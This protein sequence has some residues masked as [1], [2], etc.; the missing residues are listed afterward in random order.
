MFV[1]GQ[2]LVEVTVAEEQ[3]APQPAMRLV[4]G[5]SFKALEK[6]LVDE[7][8]IPF[9]IISKSAADTRCA[10][11]RKLEANILG[12]RLIVNC[13]NLSGLRAGTLDGPGVDVLLVARRSAVFCHCVN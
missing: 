5:H 1:L 6:L 13:G 8:G 7:R 3:A 9:P 2:N 10:I 12:E 11:S 4:A